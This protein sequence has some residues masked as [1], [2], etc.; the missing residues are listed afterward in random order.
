MRNDFCRQDSASPSRSGSSPGSPSPLS[1]GSSPR[2]SHRQLN[3]ERPGTFLGHITSSQSQPAGRDRKLRTK[4]DP[5]RDRG[6]ILAPTGFETT[7]ILCPRFPSKSRL[8]I[9]HGNGP[10]FLHDSESCPPQSPPSPIAPLFTHLSTCLCTYV[11]MC[12]R[13]SSLHTHLSLHTLVCL[14]PH[15]YPGA[16]TYPFVRVCHLCT[17]QHAVSSHALV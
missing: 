5:Q 6:V 3:T 12:A 16:H 11:S 2:P 13:V 14:C 17:Q 8:P 4:P 9:S 7:S 10:T 15:V 1:H